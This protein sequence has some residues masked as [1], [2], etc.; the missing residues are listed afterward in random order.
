M[1]KTLGFLPRRRDLTRAA[2]RDYYE[3]RHAPLA[4]SHVHVFV[5]YVRNHLAEGAAPASAFDTLSEFWYA[6]AEA[7]ASVGKWLQTA[8]GQ[9]LRED[10]AQFMDRSRIGACVAEE[11]HLH[12]P[13]RGYE[14]GPLRKLAL[15][16]ASSDSASRRPSAA[17][18]AASAALID[19]HRALVYR[20]VLD[21]PIS[22]L[23]SHVAID[24]VLWIWPVDATDAAHA[25]AS[26]GGATLLALDAIETAPQT[27]RG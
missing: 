8:A 10:E 21:V 20:A 3:R 19:R 1:L 27:L 14:P 24:G 7:A 16:L 4:L 26:E 12:G 17:V 9:V 11:H 2:F 13:E 18:M 5:K 23:P 15:L 22:P 6:D 25:L